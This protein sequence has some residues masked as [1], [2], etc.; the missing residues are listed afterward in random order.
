M[1][2]EFR[3]VV[4]SFLRFDERILILRRSSSVGSYQGR[5]AGVSGFLEEGEDPLQRAKIEIEEEVGLGNGQANLIR[6]GEPLRALD[7]KKDIVWIVHPFLFETA[8]QKI[9]L[10]WEHTE[11]RWID[12]DELPKYETV[13]K[14]KEALER[15][16]WDLKA[17]TLAYPSVIRS[18]DEL[19]KDR[20]LG[21]SRLGRRS[22]QILTD[23]A[24]ASEAESAN[25]LFSSLLSVALELRKAQPSMATIRNLTGSFLYDVDAARQT[26][27]TVEQLKETVLSLGQK[28]QAVA[29]LA[30][31][32]ASRNTAA[33]LP[34]EGYVLTHSYSE[35]VRR[36]LELG[37]KSR[38]NLTVFVTES[39]PG[40][41]GKQ[42]AKDLIAIGVPVKLI[43][44][45]AIGAVISDVDMILVGADSVL[46]D[47][48]VINKIG[49]KKIAVLAEQ[50]ETPFHVTCES[51]KFST[52]DFLGETVDIAEALFDQTPIEYVSN[53]VTEFG[54]LE[55]REV[56]HRIRMM[57]SQLYP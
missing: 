52:V 8:G 54:S 13:P 36:A 10:D 48:S 40:L 32:D 7:E 35:T 50:E 19:A 14:L 42:L 16:R 4:T 3:H 55:P 51:T 28:E 37:V 38:R 30:A 2:L 9:R 15:V 1:S 12:P 6:S 44:D 43:A 21:A 39:S 49:T 24:Q 46:A 34:E 29:E 22:I 41:E 53:I 20:V 56:E 26:A 57:L 17:I 5:W 25:E 31:E 27:N 45:S 18:V 33:I 11:S 47:G 23:V